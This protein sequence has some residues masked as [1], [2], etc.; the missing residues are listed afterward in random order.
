VETEQAAATITGLGAGEVNTSLPSASAPLTIP[1]VTPVDTRGAGSGAG[2]PG[3]VQPVTSPNSLTTTTP[4][5]VP[6][7]TPASLTVPA[8][9]STLSSIP[10][11]AWVLGGVAI[12]GIIGAIIWAATRETGGAPALKENPLPRT[13]KRKKNGRKSQERR[14]RY[15]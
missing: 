14:R 2:A 7:V 13:W 11:W 8:P 4:P 10:T 9:V 1:T 3:G 12:A 15:R 6:V 5:S